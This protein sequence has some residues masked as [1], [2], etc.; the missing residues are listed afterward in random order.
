MGRAACPLSKLSTV[1]KLGSG[2]RG[3]ADCWIK[4][5]VVYPFPGTHVGKGE[6]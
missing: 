4:Y 1:T 3:L 5:W 2:G 6:Y